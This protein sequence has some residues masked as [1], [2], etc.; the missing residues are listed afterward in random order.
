MAGASVLVGCSGG[1]DSLAL[2][3]AVAFEAPRAG[4]AAGA[5]VV[6]HRLQEGS[7]DVARRAAEQCRDMGLRPVDVARVVVRDIRA[8]PEA[9]ARAARMDTLQQHAEQLGAALVMVGHT[10]DDQA[11]QVLLG[12]A[13]G[14]GSR[15][16]SGMPS[17][18]P[19]GAGSAVV[20]VRPLLGVGR[21]TT[22]QACAAL[23]LV[24]WRDP[25][26][27][28]RRFSRVRAREAM[29]RLEEL[30]GPGV[31]AALART[32]YLLR[33]DADALE[34]A[35]DTA[36]AGLGAPPWAVSDLAALPAAVRRRVWQRVA[37]ALGAPAGALSSA[38][39]SAVDALVT[40]WHGQGP[41][42]LPGGHRV[43]RR[44]DRVCP[45]SHPQS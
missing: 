6:D 40:D 41:V 18:R 7:G 14:S 34:A 8:G 21:D 33:D 37:G 25:H 10:R 22:D 44:A 11:E 20:L 43:T 4:L 15:S 12:L 19:I 28:D 45:L 16:L 32:A 24:P 29:A 26:N 1:A 9:A 5:L 2:A 38:H 3:A 39:L 35:A 36:Y 31:P 23:G 27:T 13:R 17:A 42:D 30:L